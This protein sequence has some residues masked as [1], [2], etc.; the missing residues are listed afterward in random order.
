MFAIRVVYS[1][2]YYNDDE[3]EHHI[4]SG[5]HHPTSSCI[6]SKFPKVYKNVCVTKSIIL[7]LNLFFIYFVTHPKKYQKKL[8]LR[9][10]LE[11]K[12]NSFFWYKNFI[13]LV[14]GFRFY[15]VWTKILLTQRSLTSLIT[16]YTKINV[17]NRYFF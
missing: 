10:M 15:F 2:Y 11:E 6:S 5:C 14:C 1:W 3:E 9:K 13:W 7:F 8:R 4:H 12:T 16:F 17:K